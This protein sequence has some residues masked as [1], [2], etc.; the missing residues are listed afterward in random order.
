MIFDLFILVAFI[1]AGAVDGELYCTS[2]YGATVWQAGSTVPITWIDNGT[3]P[4]IQ[5]IGDLQIQIIGGNPPLKPPFN[6]VD[7]VATGV[8]ATDG[9]VMYTVKQDLGPPGMYYHIQFVSESYNQFSGLF[10]IQGTSG[11]F[12][13]SNSNQSGQDQSGQNQSSQDQGGAA[14]TTTI[15]SETSTDTSTPTDTSTSTDTSTTTTTTTTDDS[16]ST[17]TTTTTSETS[18]PT[19]SSNSSIRINPSIFWGINFTL[20]LSCIN[21]VI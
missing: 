1:F 8:K 11:T 18:S 7:T 13:G 17:T 20:L 4:R 2:P 21:F 14:T 5:D 6:V 12:S 3:P 15:T 9:K 19:D 16:S 10:T